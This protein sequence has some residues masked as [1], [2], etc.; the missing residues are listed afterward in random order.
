MRP[1][2][3]GRSKGSRALATGDETGT[4]D[5]SG[6]S[7][8]RLSMRKV[9]AGTPVPP[10]ADGVKATALGL[11]LPTLGLFPGLYVS[12]QSTQRICCHVCGRLNRTS[13]ATHI[14]QVDTRH[15]FARHSAWGSNTSYVFIL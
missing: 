10:K 12:R 5:H 7:C 4:T 15:Q 8:T 9:A 14:M 1:K 13:R 2:R 3:A 11:S 6:V